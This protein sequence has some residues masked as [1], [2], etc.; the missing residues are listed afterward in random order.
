MKLSPLLALASPPALQGTDK[1]IRSTFERPA[2]LNAITLD[3]RVFLAIRGPTLGVHTFPVPLPPV[4]RRRT[5]ALPA[6][7]RA[8]EMHMPVARELLKRKPP[9]TPCT[10]FLGDRLNHSRQVV[11]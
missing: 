8:A 3:P 4:P 10:A 1:R 6:T 5:M 7:R 9:A 2:T 11:V